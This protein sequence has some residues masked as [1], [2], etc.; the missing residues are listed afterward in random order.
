MKRIIP[1]IMGL[2]LLGMVGFGAYQAAAA[3]IRPDAEANHSINRM[4]SLSSTIDHDRLTTDFETYYAM[5]PQEQNALWE[6]HNA[7]QQAGKGTH[8]QTIAENYYQWY[9]ELGPRGRAELRHET[10]VDKKMVLV[11]RFLK[12]LEKQR[13]RE[14]D[15]DWKGR[16]RSYPK[17]NATDLAAVMQVVEERLLELDSSMESRLTEISD[18]PGTRRYVAVMEMVFKKYG[19]PGFRRRQ[20]ESLQDFFAD[21]RF[22]DAISDKKIRKSLKNRSQEKQEEPPSRG[23]EVRLE[24]LIISGMHAG[25]RAEIDKNQPSERD[26][27][28]HFTTLGAE[29]QDE[30][31]RLP[32]ERFMEELKN[33]FAQAHPDSYPPDPLELLPWSRRGQRP[34]GRLGPVSDRPRPPRGERPPQRG[35]RGGGR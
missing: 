27:M 14:Q 7:L 23:R 9:S 11:R 4:Q 17:L 34:D 25:Y 1:V 16:G 22:I 13:R 10:D 24:F 5:S 29:L 30:L 2:L 35:P 15:R 26:L 12:D 21:E 19:T 32:P 20:S 8:L 28:D 18:P 33:N 31:M 6:M 3:I